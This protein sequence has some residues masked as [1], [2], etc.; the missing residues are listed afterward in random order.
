MTTS[1]SNVPER[2]LLVTARTLEEGSED[3]PVVSCREMTQMFFLQSPGSGE[4][5]CNFMQT[6]LPQRTS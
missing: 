1:P 5:I 6:L 2:E 3:M 4:I